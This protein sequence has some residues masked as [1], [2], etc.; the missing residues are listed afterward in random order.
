MRRILLF[1]MVFSFAFSEDITTIKSIG[2]VVLP[3]VVV[4]DQSNLTDKRL[5]NK[6]NKI[7]I[8]D[9]RVTAVFDVVDKIEDEP[10]F[11]FKYSVQE[12]GL[13]LSMQVDVYSIQ[14]NK[15][16]L[17][18]AFLL[19]DRSR[20]P[21]LVHEAVAFVSK[22]LA[23]TD[24]D[25]M[26]DM[27]IFSRYVSQK[28]SEILVCDYTLSYQKVVI[29]G[30]LNIFPKWSD[31]TKKE[32]YYTSYLGIHPTLIR[33][34]MQSGKA[35]K[36]LEGRGMLIASDVSKDGKKVL[37][38][39]APNDQPDIYL[40]DLTTKSIK[41]ITD[42]LG[43][44]VSGNF[45]DDEKRV[46]FVSDRL[47]YPNIFAVDSDGSGAVAQLVYHGR[48]NKSITTHKNFMAYASRDGVG[49]FNIYIMS[50]KSDYIR[51]LTAGGKNDFP[52]FSHDGG[53]ILYIKEAAGQSAIGVIRINENRSFH[54]PL[55]LGKIQSLDW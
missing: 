36:I 48:R 25:W 26:K 30:G 19:Q 29:R 18:Q 9:L 22:E 24:V 42:Y 35:Y 43:I 5:Q 28:E 31:H 37:L 8:G 20:F 14:E 3:K 33:Y 15:N 34:D 32:F 41:K 55:N 7:V 52:R 39:N 2:E 17:S 44:D 16:I 10:G 54:F 13:E 23:Y 4:V 1:L 50:T 53:T 38:T 40:Y 46:A 6:I 11:I 51:Q 12:D 49:E 27:I 21:F 47:G 45:I